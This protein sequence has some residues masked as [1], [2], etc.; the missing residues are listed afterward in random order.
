MK[1]VA[2]ECLNKLLPD[3][4]AERPC[5]HVD[6]LRNCRGKTQKKRNPHAKDGHCRKTK[7]SFNIEPLGQK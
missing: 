2:K 4:L 1:A 3:R 6:R 5:A 7:P